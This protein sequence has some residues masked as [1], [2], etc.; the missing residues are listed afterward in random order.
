MV[1]R[2]PRQIVCETL[3]QKSPSQKGC[4]VVQAI[5]RLPSK[6]EALSSNPS[7]AKKKKRG[8]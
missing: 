4:G 2:Q 1:R 5:E 8:K 7:A 3:F 6:C